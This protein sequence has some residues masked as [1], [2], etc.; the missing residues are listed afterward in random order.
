MRNFHCSQEQHDAN[1][2]KCINSEHPEKIG[3]IEFLHS[4]NFDTFATFTTSLPLGLPAARRKMEN[5]VKLID[6]GSSTDFFWCAERF[7]VR[8]GFHTHG[9]INW[10]V[11]NETMRNSCNKMLFDHWLH[12]YGR[13]TL[14]PVRGKYNAEYYLTKYITK[15]ITDYDFYFKQSSKNNINS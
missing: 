6:A 7:D 4:R 13:I 2:L 10:R 3:L 12:R 11:P 5:V 14:D 1:I 9:L 15:S 8:E